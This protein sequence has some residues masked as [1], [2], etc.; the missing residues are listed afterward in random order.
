M[1]EVPNVTVVRNG[2]RCRLLRGRYADRL[3]RV[4]LRLVEAETGEPYCTATVNMPEVPLAEG[5]VLIKNYS[6]NE[7]VLAALVA[8][9]VVEDTGRRVDAGYAGAGVAVCKLK[10]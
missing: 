1:E 8:A 10:L 2:T 3:R 7:G 5:E 9:G 6:E 4:A